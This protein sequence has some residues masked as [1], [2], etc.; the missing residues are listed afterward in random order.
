LNQEYQIAGTGTIDPEGN[1]GRIGGIDK[2]IVAADKQG[3]AIFFAPEDEITEDMRKVMPDIKTN[4]EEAL[5]AAKAI[6]TKMKVIPIQ[7]LQDAI[8]YLEQLP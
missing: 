4:Y 7:T 1:V 3:A 8:D 6:G 5:A 2:K